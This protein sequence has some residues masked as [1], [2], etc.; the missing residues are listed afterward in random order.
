P[1][2]L[3]LTPLVGAIAAGNC[4]LL[5]PSEFAPATSS[6]IKK[7]MD[8]NFDPSYILT[9]EGSGQDVIPKLMNIYRFDHIFYTGNSHVGKMVY[10]QAAKDLIP[11]TLELGGKS[12]CIIEKDA[13]IKVAAKRIAV[14]KF[15]NA[16]QMC[17]APDYLLL[18]KDIEKEFIEEL[19]KYIHDF[20]MAEDVRDYHY[21]KIVNEKHFNRLQ[22][23][24]KNANISFGGNIDVQQKHI[25]PT[26]LSEVD[27]DDS[28]MQE[29]IFGPLLPVLVW[30]KEEEV[31]TCINRNKEPLSLYVFTENKKKADKW[32][33]TISFGGG[34]INNASWHLTNYNLPFGGRGYSG[35]GNY[36]GKFSFDTFSHK[37]A[38]MRTP[39]WFD[40]AIKY[41]PY[42]GKLNLFKKM[43]R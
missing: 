23:Y 37:K 39:T 1:V 34:C 17:V 33:N 32:I 3:L 16:G 40:P 26:I 42:K 13:N 7:I 15:S 28:V 25:Q 19:K 20:Y 29:E 21:G 9:V 36:H 41:P 35:I 38:I 11:V 43:I 14:T 22:G 18:H 2:Q 27:I 4:I 5:K 10:E 6:L 8:E 30:E 31:Y 24:L 12:P